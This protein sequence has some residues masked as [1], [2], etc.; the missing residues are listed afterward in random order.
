M[1]LEGEARTSH[2]FS[3]H[4]LFKTEGTV[5][6]MDIFENPNFKNYPITGS[7]LV[8]QGITG[9]EVS[10]AVAQVTAAARVRSL[11]WELL[12]A[13]AAAKNKI[14]NHGMLSLLSYLLFLCKPIPNEMKT[15]TCN[16][17][18]TCSHA[19]ICGRHPGLYMR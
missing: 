6:L 12:H 13:V 2:V 16:S 7:P 8:V 1:S 11:A 4:R 19:E 10:T 9:L 5:P 14:S 3:I 17:E 15:D 18:K